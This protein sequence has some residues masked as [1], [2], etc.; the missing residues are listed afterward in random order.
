MTTETKKSAGVDRNDEVR[1]QM[2]AWF[3]EHVPSCGKSESMGGEVCRAFARINYRYYNDGDR[4]GQG[5]GNET[6]NA[7]A[8]YLKDN[9]TALV[10]EI[11][12]DMWGSWK[13][14]AWYEEMLAALEDVLHDYL[15][16]HPEAFSEP[17]KD[18]WDWFDKN[19]DRDDEWDDEEDW[20]GEEW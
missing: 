10:S 13:S 15:S 18:M 5:Y 19:E 1:E 8:R 4:I 14:D 12:A 2:N 16:L 17:T 3:E 9:T 20:D 7:A 6:C 11:I